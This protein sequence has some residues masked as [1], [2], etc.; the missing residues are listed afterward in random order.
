MRKEFESFGVVFYLSEKFF[1][2]FLGF[3]FFGK[4]ERKIWDRVVGYFVEDGKEVKDFVKDD[5]VFIFDF[6]DS[7]VVIMGC[8][9][10]GIFNIVWYVIDLI[11]KLIKVLIGGFYLRGVFEYFLD[12]VVEGFREFGVGIFYVGYCIGIDEYVYFKEYFGFV[13]FLFV[14]KEIRV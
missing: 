14:G 3:I 13:E 6:G 2:F 8:G 11:R 12:D 9:Y 5:I 7:V 1:E 4:I 10:S